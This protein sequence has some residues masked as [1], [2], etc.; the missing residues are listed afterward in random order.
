L[1]SSADGNTISTD[2]GTLNLQAQIFPENATFNVL[3]WM[4]I[5]I[6]GKAI[7][8][9][10]GVVTSVKDGTVKVVVTST[11][12]SG[13][14]S[15]LL[16]TI[17]NQIYPVESILVTAASNTLTSESGTLQLQ[18]S[19][20]PIDA[21][22]P[23]VTWSVIDLTGK[24][25]ISSSG[26]LTSIKNGTVKVL[27]TATDGSGVNG[28]LIITIENASIQ[29]SVKVML[30]GANN[31][32]QM[33][34]LLQDYIPLMQPYNLAPW[35]Y[36]G[37][38][39]VETIPPNVVD[40]VLVELRQAAAA[41][42]ATSSSILAKCAA[43]LKSDG[44]IVDHLTGEILRFSNKYIDSDNELFVV[45]RHRNH[46]AIMSSQGLTNTDGVYLYD[47]T[48]NI[49]QA[50]GGSTGY[51]TTGMVAGDIDQDG[52]VF[53]S[54]YNTWA[55]GFGQTN[56]Y[57]SSDLNLD[58]NVFVSDYNSWSLNFGGNTATALKSSHINSRYSSNVPH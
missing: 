58:G 42:E 11:D 23:T 2:N 20:L 31:G 6:T 24:A 55:I 37:T 56:G 34:T 14:K 48:A 4:V 52:N 19:V 8:S 50:Y 12:G 9:S 17:S 27:A 1:I 54:D 45:I 36:S 53:V 18:A 38:E 40:W 7:I 33:S 29:L 16:I 32:N 21:T 44:T 46:L 28:E 49:N 43:F 35:N 5:E 25:T 13:V 47:F 26:L 57:F 51:K 10:S 41:P 15:E 39:T 30:E 22:T 3:K